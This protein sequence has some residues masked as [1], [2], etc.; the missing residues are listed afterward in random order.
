MN[1]EGMRG[2]FSGGVGSWEG[3][4]GDGCDAGLVHHKAGG[5]RMRPGFIEWYLL[6][7]RNK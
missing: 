4:G 1:I 7:V 2:K 3:G 5:A 6:L